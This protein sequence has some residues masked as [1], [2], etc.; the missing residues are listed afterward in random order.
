MAKRSW[1]RVVVVVAL[2]ASAESLGLVWQQ[3]AP[4]LY[5]GVGF[6]DEPYRFLAPP[7]HYRVTA[8]PAAA[9]GT[10]SIENGFSATGITVSSTERGPQVALTVPQGNVRAPIGVSRVFLR[11][12]PISP[13]GLGVPGHAW[14]NVYR[15]TF[16]SAAQGAITVTDAEIQMRAPTPEQPG[17]TLYWRSSAD[18]SWS[19]LET[20]RTGNDIYA[21]PLPAAGD[22]VLAAARPFS[23]GAPD[24]NNEA[25]VGLIG[26]AVSGLGVVVAVLLFIRAERRRSRRRTV[27]KV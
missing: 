22:Y 9:G 7:P 19:S 20:H 25:G 21:G 27:A 18:R 10:V 14:T 26:F 11:A 2:C 24:P 17:P 4:P 23:L 1:R 16:A 6:P 3:G 12:A 13:V 15:V 5:D 8:P